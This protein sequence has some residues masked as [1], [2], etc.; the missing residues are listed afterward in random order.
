MAKYLIKKA[1]FDEIVFPALDGRGTRSFDQLRV[2]DALLGKLEAVGERPR[3][4][5][6]EDGK[7]RPHTGPRV[8]MASH[9]VELELTPEETELLHGRLQRALRRYDVERLRQARYLTDALDAA[10]QE[11]QHASR[12]ADMDQGIQERRQVARD[13]DREIRRLRAE[14][15]R[16][17]KEVEELTP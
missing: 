1:E 8:V 10:V 5:K 15:D 6:G 17:T 7:P 11:L 12:L 2:G 4:E 14:R 13:L 9:E 16:L 3:I